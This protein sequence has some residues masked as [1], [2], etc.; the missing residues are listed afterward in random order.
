MAIVT[1][2]K[3]EV[4]MNAVSILRDSGGAPTEIGAPLRFGQSLADV[5]DVAWVSDVRLAVVG[6]QSTSSTS[7]I[8]VVGIGTPTTSLAA[9]DGVVDLTAGRGLDTI[10]IQDN[11]NRLFSYDGAGWRL[12]ADGVTAPALPG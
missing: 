3:G 4:Q 5:T 10:I 8:H 7:S 12:I 9:V 11:S 6:R 1:D 2:Q